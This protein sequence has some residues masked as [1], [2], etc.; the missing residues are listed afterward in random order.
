MS[1]QTI[2][3]A[4]K[5]LQRVDEIIKQ[6][7]EIKRLKGENFNVFSVLK[8]ESAENATH[9]A[10]LG[11]LLNPKGSHECGSVFLKL[12]LE[13]ISFE[14]ANKNNRSINLDSASVELE[15]Y[16]GPVDLQ[17][18]T[19]GRID[20]FISDNEGIS[21][22]IEN[23]IYAGDQER[24]V[25]RYCN[26][27]PDRNIVYYLKLSRSEPDEWSS[28]D[29]KPDKD[30]YCISYKK[31]I[32]NW[33]SQCLKEAAEMPILRESIKQYII[34]IKKLTGQL[35]DHKM[36]NELFDV[37][38]K[39]PQSARSIADEWETA[40]RKIAEIFL[41][42]V[43]KNLKKE[44]GHE[45]KVDLDNIGEKWEYLWIEH[46]EWGGL[47]IK[48][49]GNEYLNG[50]ETYYGIVGHK[51]EFDHDEVQQIFKENSSLK[52]FSSTDDWPV[53]WPHIDFSKISERD[54]LF[55]DE[56][57]KVLVNLTVDKLYQLVEACTDGLKQIQRKASS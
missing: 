18:G 3:D 2:N 50:C 51:D 7:D 9:S 32:I 19:G 42:E 40:E 27:K 1:D 34:L 57:R 4:E 16:I 48:L 30:F 5:L 29:L 41:D 33:L 56:E 24:Q 25:E 11:E 39:N 15:K 44:L 13:Q 35:T 23:K 55:D 37:I 6:N 20:I 21:L 8:M 46:N 17:T 12:F 10:F 43:I 26:Y 38:K 45:Y 36:Q 28:G 52:D 14:K 54:K 22:S 53:F 31:T 49:E 47:H